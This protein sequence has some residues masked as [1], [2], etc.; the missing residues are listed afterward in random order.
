M[1]RA[2]ELTFTHTG[3]AEI[4][5]GDDILWS[6]DDDDEFRDEFVDE[7]LTEKDTDRVL[8]WLVDNDVITEDESEDIEVFQEDEDDGGTT[9][10]G[11][12]L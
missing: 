1:T 7:F 10:E 9:I 6:S 12:A 3:G 2:L 11:E 5:Q 4:S 8:Q